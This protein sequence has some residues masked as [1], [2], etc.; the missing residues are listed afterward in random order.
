MRECYTENP[1]HRQAMLDGLRKV[2]E[3]CEE[4]EIA[5]PPYTWLW[6]RVGIW[7]DA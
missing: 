5:V 4:V 6:R 2:R 3:L 1:E 7:D